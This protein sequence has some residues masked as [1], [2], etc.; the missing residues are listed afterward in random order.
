MPEV[1]VGV[2]GNVKPAR[3]IP[4]G[5]AELTARVGPL[6][7]SPVYRSRAVGFAGDDF[8][9]LVVA[10]DTDLE[11]HALDRVLDEVETACGRDRTAPRFAS[12]TLDLDLL[13]YGDAVIDEPGLK[14]P[15][16]EI[17]DYAFVLRPLAELA[18]DRCH[19]S[20]GLTFAEHWQRY[21]DGEPPLVPVELPVAA[22]R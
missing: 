10:F 18:G 13:L 11:V 6:R 21:R 19:P 16:R 3:H 2:G 5:L 8:Y 9:N 4:R 7:L 22:I 1:F 15:R 14:L 17:L 20:T 12:R